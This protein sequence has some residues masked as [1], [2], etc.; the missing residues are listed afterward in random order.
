MARPIPRS[1]PRSLLAQSLLAIAITLL[2]GQVVSGILL[3]R[4]VE[5]RRDTASANAAAFHLMRTA[6]SGPEARE[7]RRALR[8]ERGDRID[9]DIGP[10]PGRPGRRGPL[11]RRLSGMIA[12]SSPLLAGETRDPAAEERV[13][14]IL[15]RQ[16]VAVEELVVT[17]RPL[18]ADPLLAEFAQLRPRLRARMAKAEGK[19]LVAGMRQ[20][21]ES[22]WIVARSMSPPV[23]ARAL[24]L[25]AGQT[26]LLFLVLLGATY[27]VLRRITHP[28][29]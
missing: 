1:F 21:G 5:E 2:I 20:P 23:E 9:F 27:L 18:A 10:G 11:P 26:V 25:I 14:G 15:E 16:G 7:I 4:M 29:N 28:N 19:L 8:A 13:R 22:R 17:S 6:N 24:W 12:D 3:Y